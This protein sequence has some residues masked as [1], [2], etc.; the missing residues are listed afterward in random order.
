MWNFLK[1]IIFNR[2]PTL[3]N[4]AQYYVLKLHF[5]CLE[6][7]AIAF[8]FLFSKRIIKTGK[9]TEIVSDFDFDFDVV[10]VAKSSLTLDD[11]NEHIQKIDDLLIA[12]EGT[13]GILKVAIPVII[14][15]SKGPAGWIQAGLKLVRMLLKGKFDFHFQPVLRILT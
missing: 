7:M 6:K 12:I 4:V 8:K 5:L 15:L 10:T 14:T 2:L 1:T 13:F 9:Q 11:K 3:R